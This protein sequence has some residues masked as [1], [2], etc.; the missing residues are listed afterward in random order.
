[1]WND[2][3]NEK[4]SIKKVKKIRN[5]IIKIMFAALLAL[6]LIVSYFYFNK[7]YNIK[8]TLEVQVP[9]NCE[10]VSYEKTAEVIKA[11]IKVNEE[12]LNSILVDVKKHYWEATNGVRQKECYSIL[13]KF[14][15]AEEKE[16]EMYWS[17]I[18]RTRL[19]TIAKTAERYVFV[20][21]G[22]NEGEYYVCLFAYIFDFF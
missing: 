5:T 14:G 22:D 12:E 20:I 15:I 18:S 11:M 3:S 21:R 7:S 6:L 9:S 13:K 16:V 8:R 2:I 17:C 19:F 4:R 1:M 10:F